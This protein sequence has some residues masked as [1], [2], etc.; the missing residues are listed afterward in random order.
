MTQVVNPHSFPEL[1]R[2]YLYIR[3]GDFERAGRIIARTL[4]DDPQNVDGWWLAAFVTMDVERKRAA[5]IRVL[6]LQPD[7]GPA[8]TL[9]QK[10]GVP[11]TKKTSTIETPIFERSTKK[12]K[13][14]WLYVVL[15][16]FGILA[17]M[18]VPL[19]VLD[20]FTGGEI[21]GRIERALFGEPDA[22]GWVDV[23][24]GGIANED[25]DRDERIPIVKRT[26]VN[27]GGTPIVSTISHGEAHQYLLNGRRGDEL[28]IAV[29]FTAN[30]DSDVIALE[31]WDQ[32]GRR[33]A[34]EIQDLPF[35]VPILSGRAMTY[36][37]V[38]SGS[39]S[40]VVVSRD[41]GPSG[42]YTLSVTTIDDVMEEYGNSFQ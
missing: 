41:G 8:R 9:I 18:S 21:T 42:N 3:E 17:S 33:L 12:R 27:L 34:Y 6:S 11:K 1:G 13:V 37:V 10:L 25:I 38:Q 23:E 14:K 31:F 40:V 24:S 5:L 15:M 16:A 7:H 26:G 2:A 19:I 29:A 32:A 35:E 36:N 22:I 4:K 28:V 30:G 20:N 39:Y